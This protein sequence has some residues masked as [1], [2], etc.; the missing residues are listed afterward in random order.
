VTGCWRTVHNEDVYYL[1]P[2]R[3]NVRVTK[4]RNMRWAKD[5]ALMGGEKYSKL[6]S[7]NMKGRD[8]S[9]DFCLVWKVTLELIL[10]KL[11]GNV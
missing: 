5:V 11:G 8:H 9:D 10:G 4:S 7:R 3:N 1:S 6:W 2:S